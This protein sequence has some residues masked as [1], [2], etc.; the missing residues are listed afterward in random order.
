MRKLR[1][2]RRRGRLLVDIEG[3]DQNALLRLTLSGL[4]RLGRGLRLG[5]GQNKDKER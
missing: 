5:N 1:I 3:Q 2:H 4:A